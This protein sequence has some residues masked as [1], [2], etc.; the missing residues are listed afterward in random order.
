MESDILVTPEA[1]FP[2]GPGVFKVLDV[3]REGVLDLPP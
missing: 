3:K 1:P 2:L